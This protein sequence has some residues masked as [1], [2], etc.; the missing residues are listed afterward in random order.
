MVIG[1]DLNLEGLWA[2]TMG[3]IVADGRKEVLEG[4]G[5]VVDGHDSNVGTGKTETEEGS[6]WDQKRSG[7]W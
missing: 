3:G 7:I 1:C 4:K 6:T 5:S 2:S